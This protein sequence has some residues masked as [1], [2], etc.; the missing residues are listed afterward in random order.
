[1]VV[2]SAY[3][4]R[5]WILK[6]SIARCACSIATCVYANPSESAL[7]IHRFQEIYRSFKQPQAGMQSALE[8]EIVS[9]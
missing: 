2:R 4:A 8:P 7:S 5:T 6:S 1:M 3:A 9:L